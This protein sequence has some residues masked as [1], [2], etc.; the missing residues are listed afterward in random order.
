MGNGERP[1]ARTT[2]TRGQ[3]VVQRHPIMQAQDNPGQGEGK[4]RHGGGYNGQPAA[5]HVVRHQYDI[6]TYKE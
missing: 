2:R 3:G 5:N 4:S 1:V 6:A